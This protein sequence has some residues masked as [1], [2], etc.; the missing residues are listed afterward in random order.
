[1]RLFFSTLFLAS[2]FLSCSGQTDQQAAGLLSP[3]D[4]E[5][6]LQ[7]NTNIQLV[8]V[9]TPQEYNSG[10][11]K[12]AVNFNFNGPDFEKQIAQLDKN[13]PVMVYCAVG[14]RSGKSTARLQKLGFTQVYD[15]AGGMTAWK[16][17]GKPV[18][19]K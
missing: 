18:V 9:R 11:V 16:Q 2:F 10:Y 1:M 17:A 19:Q 5:K 8:D 4:F 3:N 7:S 12:D 13:R 15:L 14:G 6:M